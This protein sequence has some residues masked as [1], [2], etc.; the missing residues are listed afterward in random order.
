MFSKCLN[1]IYLTAYFHIN[2]KICNRKIHVIRNSCWNEKQCKIYLKDYT[3]SRTL[4]GT[5]NVIIQSRIYI[6]G[7]TSTCPNLI[8]SLLEPTWNP[9][10]NNATIHFIHFIQWKLLYKSS[11]AV[12]GFVNIIILCTPL[13]LHYSFISRVF[14]YWNFII[15]VEMCEIYQ[16]WVMNSKHIYQIHNSMSFSRKQ[17]P[18][19][20]LLEKDFSEHL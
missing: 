9:K 6:H 16:K 14:E 8:L 17:I 2:E 5:F 13:H 19:K 18:V 12:I 3:V 10:I 20:W 15:S 7:S 1:V 11:S 4:L